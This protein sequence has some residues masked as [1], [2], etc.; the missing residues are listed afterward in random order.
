MLL[1]HPLRTIA[2]K[3]TQ[4]FIDATY[5]QIIPY[6]ATSTH[7]FRFL[8]DYYAQFDNRVPQTQ[9]DRT[10]SNNDR[11]DMS[12]A[13]D[14]EEAVAATPTLSEAEELARQMPDYNTIQQMQ[15]EQLHQKQQHLRQAL[16]QKHIEEEL[17]ED[18]LFNLPQTVQ[19]RQPELRDTS[20]Y[21]Q[22][23]SLPHQMPDHQTYMYS[24][25]MSEDINEVIPAKS[26]ASYVYAKPDQVGERVYSGSSGSFSP[27]SNSAS[28]DLS[29]LFTGS[30]SPSSSYGAS[31]SPSTSYGDVPTTPDAVSRFFGVTGTTS[32]D[33]QLGLTFTVPFLSIPLNSLQSALGGGGIG[34]LF[35]G[36]GDFDTTSLITVAVI[37]MAAIFILPQVI[38]WATGVNLSAFNWGRSKYFCHFS[39]KAG[40][41]HAF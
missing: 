25:V 14:Y 5:T 2:A 24:S 13:T 37:A 12:Y 4:P 19:Q 7:L 40:K 31:S 26:V 21:V 11:M 8:D 1:K 9:V 29:R 30:S 17:L 39:N 16:K 32:Q 28:S 20:R 18:E 10:L 41:K 15:Q 35:G 36:F 34:D 27:G 22:H 3:I 33:I 38:Y 23:V 6:H